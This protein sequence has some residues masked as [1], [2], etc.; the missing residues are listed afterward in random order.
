MSLRKFTEKELSDISNITYWKQLFPDMEI[1]QRPFINCDAR[2]TPEAKALDQAEYV[3]QMKHEGYVNLQSILPEERMEKMA[4]VIIK[5]LDEGFPPVMCFIFDDF[6]QI[7]KEMASVMSPIIG[8][9]YMISLNRWAWYLPPDSNYAGFSP[10]RDMVGSKFPALRED[11]LPM[12]TTA[13]VPLRDVTADNACLY[14]LPQTR[15][16]NIPDNMMQLGVPFDKLQDIKALPAKTGSVLSWNGNVMHWG[17]RASPWCTEPRI[18]IGAYL[19]RSEGA[20]LSGVRTGDTDP[21]T[22]DFRLG[23]IGACLEH[24]NDD[25]LVAET[26]SPDLIAHL[27]KYRKCAPGEWRFPQADG[28]P[29]E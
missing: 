20:T 5:L 24:Y 6:W 14:L 18:S 23:A 10:H 1:T 26:F 16:P 7:Y 11:G 17:G 19:M 12:I 25:Q 13:W 3:K 4:Q 9:D 8:E 28:A 2:I 22:F 27:K 29:L 15:D 21:V